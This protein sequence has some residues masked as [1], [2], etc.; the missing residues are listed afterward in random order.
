MQYNHLRSHKY[1]HTF[2]PNFIFFLQ[3]NHLKVL[4]QNQQKRQRKV[5]IFKTSFEGNKEK[6][7]TL[8]TRLILGWRVWMRRNKLENLSILDSKLFRRFS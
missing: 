6:T 8:N 3:K 1:T 7:D 5:I 2:L 4:R